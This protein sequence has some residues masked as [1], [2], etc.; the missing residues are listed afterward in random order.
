MRRKRFLSLLAA[1]CLLCGTASCAPKSSR[2]LPEQQQPAVV[3]LCLKGEVS[4]LDRVLAELY[5]K[6][7]NSPNIRLQITSLPDTDYANALA[8]RLAAHEDFDLVFDAPW[9]SMNRMISRGNYQNLETYFNSDSYPGLE[10][11][12]SKDYVDANRFNGLIYGVPIT[13]TYLDPAGIFYR[14][15][16]LRSLGLGFTEIDSREQ[17]FQF[18]DAVLSRD[19]QLTPLALGSRGFYIFNMEDQ[20]LRAHH[21]YDVT[22]WSVFDYPA[23]LILDS[24]GTRVLD[25]VFAGDDPQRFQKLGAPYNYDFLSEFFLKNAACSQYIQK[26]SLIA[27]LGKDAFLLG[28]SASFEASIGSGSLDVQRQTRAHVPDAEVGFWCY[29]DPF[30]DGK[31]RPGGIYSLMQAWNFLCVPSYAS[32]VRPAMQ[33]LDWLFSDRSRLELFNYGVPGT[34]WQAKPNNEYELLNSAK[35]IF[36]FPAYELAWSPLYHRVQSSLPENEKQILN[37]AF[38]KSSYTTIPISGWSLD[39]SRISI[40]LT[41][42]TALY[43]EYAPAFS[44]GLYGSGTSRKIAELHSRSLDVGLETVR[45]EIVSQAQYYLDYKRQLR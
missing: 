14:K 28:K 10:R 2:T 18:Y 22:G 21:I 9:L 32:N 39:T 16:I 37:Y 36:T 1:L 43:K 44:H 24:S 42:L 20:Q 3:K 35:K 15:D 11:A 13:N 30:Q 34:D 4:G 40:E 5:R 25:V 38:D 19:P 31:R 26:D 29:E 23:K 12:F 17:L 27:N 41:R 45:R 7:G 8:L 6:M 33:F